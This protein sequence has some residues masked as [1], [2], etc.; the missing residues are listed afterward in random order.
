M[1]RELAPWLET[2]IAEER[3]RLRARR[4]PHPEVRV[5]RVWARLFPGRSRRELM[6]IALEYELAVN[7]SWPAPGC[8]RL[9]ACLR[10]LP[11]LLGLLSNAQFYTPLILTALL[12]APPEKVGFSRGLCVYSYRHGIAKP[13][14]ALL[15]IALSRLE[16]RGVPRG[17]IV[18]VGDDLDNDI[19]PAARAGLMTVLI[20][21][22]PP[23]GR[24]LP[25]VLASRLFQIREL[26]TA[27]D[28]R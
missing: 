4:V 21:L 27:A 14:P 18:V 23:P 28:P 19:I 15:G 17:S 2:A 9:L 5:E 1:P 6:K 24:F 25:D 16:A 20:G 3:Q 22:A 26:L 7:P 12:G 8:S 11:V 10:R 13:D